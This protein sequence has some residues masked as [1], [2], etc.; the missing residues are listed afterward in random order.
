MYSGI[1]QLA[2]RV[3]IASLL[4]FSFQA[5]ASS[6]FNITN[7]SAAQPVKP[8]MVHSGVENSSVR[9]AKP[10]MVQSDYNSSA[11]AGAG[12]N[13]NRANDS[14]A[15]PAKPIMMKSGDDKSPVHVAKPTMMKSDDKAS[16]NMTGKR[17]FFDG[18]NFFMIKGGVGKPTHGGVDALKIFDIQRATYVAGAVIGR[19]FNDLLAFDLEYR[20]HP[21]SR[22][23]STN[24]N[25]DDKSWKLRSHNITANARVNLVKDST[26]VPYLRGGVG[27]SVNK[28]SDLI[29]KNTPTLFTYFPGDTTSQFTW[30]AGLG[31][32]FKYNSVVS[33]SLEYMYANLGKFKTKGS[34]VTTAN[35]LTSSA[36]NSPA[37][38]KF[39][40]HVI[41]FGLKFSF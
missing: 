30:Q 16:A 9:V 24:P 32:N 27:L 38:A 10:T 36:A 33:T 37:T 29:A 7:D 13:F 14:A 21:N 39:A 2:L 31:L 25:T 41:T 6:N 8:T 5:E 15:Q 20:F 40:E 28:A 11:Q 19:D 1:N 26:V 12:S 17:K 34:K 35:G 23:I 3:G 4:A 22:S 18:K